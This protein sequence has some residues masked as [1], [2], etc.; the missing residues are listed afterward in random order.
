MLKL[1]ET[2]ALS[3]YGALAPLVEQV[4]LQVVGIPPDNIRRDATGET[5]VTPGWSVFEDDEGRGIAVNLQRGNAD[6][7]QLQGRFNLFQQTLVVAGALKA[8]SSE[9]EL[10][11]SDGDTCPSDWAMFYVEVDTRTIG[12]AVS[13][14]PPRLMA[15]EPRRT[16][17]DAVIAVHLTALCAWEGAVAVGEYREM[18]TLRVALGQGDVTGVLCRREEGEMTMQLKGVEGDERG[19][20]EENMPVKIDLGEVRLSLEQLLAVRRGMEISLDAEMPLRCY[21]RIGTTIIAEAV[22]ELESNGV[23]L[24]IVDVCDGDPVK[25]TRAVSLH[26]ATFDRLVSNS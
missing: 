26:H 18:S 22:L 7:T 3:E 20:G 4:I 8:L 10:C 5:H 14:P 23:R 21:M 2:E 9:A 17:R 11:L 1:R 13:G 19:L 15:H 16:L 12:C 24:T 6:T 25:K